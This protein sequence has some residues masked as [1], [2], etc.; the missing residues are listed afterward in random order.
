LAGVFTE[1]KKP[2]FIIQLVLCFFKKT[3]FWGSSSTK[4]WAGDGLAGIHSGSGGW[5]KLA[6]FF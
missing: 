4:N 5:P 1:G 6:A 3:F 2:V